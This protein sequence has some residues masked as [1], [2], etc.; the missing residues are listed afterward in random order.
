MIDAGPLDPH[1][2]CLSDL[3]EVLSIESASYATPWT[4][5]MF[6]EEMS[7]EAAHPIV[8]TERGR[9][10]GYLC[11]WE[12]LDEAHLLNIAVRPDRRGHG[13]GMLFMSHLDRLCRERGLSKIF[14]DVGRRNAPARKL[15]RKSGFRSIGFR[16]NYYPEVQDDALV[17]EKE[18]QRLPDSDVH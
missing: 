8:F 6:V 13:L 9:V 7:N 16:K 18:V 10:V 1:P 3:D 2:M 5:N 12:I 11:F 17:M 15:Y 14:L 4:Q